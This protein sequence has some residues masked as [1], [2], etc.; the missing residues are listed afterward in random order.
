MIS[1]PISKI[2]ESCFKL[3][4]FQQ[5]IVWVSLIRA[6]KTEGMNMN[7]CNMDELNIAVYNC[8]DLPTNFSLHRGHETYSQIF[9]EQ[10][11]H[12]IKMLK[13]ISPNITQPYSVYFRPSGNIRTLK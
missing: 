10:I 2:D 4:I 3:E 13:G 11:E 5:F 8:K 9:A 1:L 7:E 6:N 12:T